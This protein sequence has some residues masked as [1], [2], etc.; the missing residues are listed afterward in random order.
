MAD[1]PMV[2]PLLLLGW[3]LCHEVH[4]D[5]LEPEAGDPLDEPGEGRLIGQFSAERCHPPAYGDVA[6]I[7]FR[8]QGSASLARESDLI[9]L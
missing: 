2:D 1:V 3:W 5:D 9:C 7:E 6:V 4:V 8:A